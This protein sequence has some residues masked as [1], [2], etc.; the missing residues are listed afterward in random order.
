MSFWTL[1]EALSRHLGAEAGS[2]VARLM[3]EELGGS[4]V[5]VPTFRA[6]ARSARDEAIRRA[7]TGRNLKEL[8][9]EHGLTTR[10][11]RRI[12]KEGPG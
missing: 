12:L 8:S 6:L 3:C 10:Q 4:C 1:A 5:Y 9:L 7:F 2:G 11:V